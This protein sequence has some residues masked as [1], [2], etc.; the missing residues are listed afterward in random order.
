MIRNDPWPSHG[1][2][3]IGSTTSVALTARVTVAGRV[4]FGSGCPGVVNSTSRLLLGS[5]WEFSFVSRVAFAHGWLPK[6]GGDSVSIQL[7]RLRAQLVIWLELFPTH[8]IRFPL[9]KLPFTIFFHLG[10]HL[11]LRRTLPPSDAA[12][13]MCGR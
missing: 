8:F 6:Q 11:P 10:C 2:N 12:L 9:K 3:V 13:E 7:V 1:K 5:P 4:H